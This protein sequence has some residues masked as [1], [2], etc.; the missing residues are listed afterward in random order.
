MP[1]QGV[2]WAIKPPWK[3]AVAHAGI[4]IDPI[5]SCRDFLASTLDAA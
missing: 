3:V 2:N 1:G 5:E 4:L